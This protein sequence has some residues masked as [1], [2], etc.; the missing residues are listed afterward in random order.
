VGAAPRYG[1][2][3]ELARD[4]EEL[5]DDDGAVD[6]DDDLPVVEGLRL[7]GSRADRLLARAWS[8]ALAVTGMDGIP[9][10]RAGGNVLRPFTEA[11]LSIRLPPTADAGAAAE[12]V[13]R[14]LA[15]DPPDGAPVHV[16]VETGASGWLAPE[17][18][19]W[20]ARAIEAGSRA[21]FGRPAGSYGEGGTIPFLPMLGQ[22]FAGVPMV[23]TGVLGPHSNA[24]GPNEF[25]HLPMA[26]GVTLA[27]VHLIAAVR[28]APAGTI[29]ADQPAVPDEGSR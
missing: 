27:L 20:L 11:K 18:G 28:R 21:A 19:P 16:T 23:A 7:G 14:A 10:V 29:A 22:R 5:E 13:R 8:P 2:G 17:P 12:A 6:D 26:R 3:N 15:S 9:S 4:L 25:L 1:T 24:H